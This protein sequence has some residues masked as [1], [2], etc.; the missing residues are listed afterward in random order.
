MII[1]TN[2]SEPL[3]RPPEPYVVPGSVPEQGNI[4]YWFRGDDHCYSDVAGTLLCH[5]GH[6]VANWHNAGNRAENAIQHTAINRPVYRLGGA[7]GRPYLE[8]NGTEFFEDLALFT[9]GSGTTNY[10]GWDAFAAV[11]ELE[12]NAA[13]YPIFGGPGTAS[14]IK[15]DF[16]FATDG[17]FRP[18]KSQFS[19]GSFPAGLHSLACTAPGSA[20]SR[21]SGY[22]HVASTGGGDCTNAP[23]SA[24]GST[25]FLHKSATG[26]TFKGKVYEVIMWNTATGLFSTAQLDAILAYFNAKYAI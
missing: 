22:D 11:V 7:G 24:A 13:R 18:W 8:C 25:Q 1:G 19:F 17:S 15:P 20:C 2:A 26:E 3:W 12:D 23:S 21:S 10:S 5:D 9:W 4:A 14:Y 6:R 16:Y